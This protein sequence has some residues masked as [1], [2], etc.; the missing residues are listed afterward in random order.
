MFC[1]A[2]C[3][4]CGF[5]RK[6]PHTHGKCFLFCYQGERGRG[7]SLCILWLWSVR[8]SV[9]ACKVCVCVTQGRH[10]GR[11][12]LSLSPG[13]A[14]ACPWQAAVIRGAQRT[15]FI[16]LS[17]GREAFRP[18]TLQFVSHTWRHVTAWTRLD[19]A[20]FATSF[21]TPMFARWGVCMNRITSFSPPVTLLWTCVAFKDL[22]W[23]SASLKDW[24][25]KKCWARIVD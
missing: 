25:L 14:R 7:N 22:L 1:A 13:G 20:R 8:Q 5:L 4:F 24:R 12:S 23:S 19:F 10:D 2:V 6:T 18:A 3:V 11:L 9:N 21:L 15:E 17:R 16:R